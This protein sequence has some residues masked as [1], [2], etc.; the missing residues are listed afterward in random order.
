MS[1]SSADWSD[2]LSGRAANGEKLTLSTADLGKALG[3]L[4][5][6]RL[7]V[8][9]TCMPSS[10]SRGRAHFQTRLPAQRVGLGEAIIA[11]ARDTLGLPDHHPLPEE[12]LAERRR[13]D[14]FRERKNDLVKLV[15]P[16]YVHSL[17]SLLTSS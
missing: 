15:C 10:F 12:L 11:H 6:P 9:F 8:L 2:G 5:I 14:A 1:D 7:P 13:Q 4:S 17:L 3:V 16:I